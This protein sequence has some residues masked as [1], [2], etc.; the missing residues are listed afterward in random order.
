MK[1]NP[2]IDDSGLKLLRVLERLMY[3]ILSFSA[4]FTNENSKL[5][6]SLFNKSTKLKYKIRVN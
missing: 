1:S 3:T 5:R 2:F 4:G 6:I